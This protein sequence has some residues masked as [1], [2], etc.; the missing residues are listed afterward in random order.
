MDYRWDKKILEK[1]YL[2]KEVRKEL[3]Y[4]YASINFHNDF[5]KNNEDDLTYSL[6]SVMSKDM[7]YLSFFPFLNG[8]LSKVKTNYKLY[9]TDDLKSNINLTKE[10]ILSLTYDFYKNIDKEIFKT[11]EN[12]FNERNTHLKFITSKYDYSGQTHYSK[13][14]NEI[15]IELEYSNSFDNLLTAVHEYGHAIRFKT[16]KNNPMTISRQAY[17]EI[18]S[19]FMEILAID[20]FTN[21]DAF[22]H[23]KYNE[24]KKY[25]NSFYT[26]AA[27][28]NFKMFIKYLY[29]NFKLNND[30][31]GYTAFKHYLNDNYNISANQLK[32]IY[33]FTSSYFMRYV[34]S[35]FVTF[36]LYSI[37]N[38]DK[39][40]AIYLYK[41]ILKLTDEN[42]IDIDNKLKKM[43]IIIGNNVDAF[44]KKLERK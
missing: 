17:Q 25:F 22:K 8:P 5:P 44:T 35:L 26:Q 40:K 10:D 3:Y 32:Q 11:F 42:P 18:E 41:E 6:K 4:L 2:N 31:T 24:K 37:Y 33:E 27:F 38:S 29:D 1:L 13:S 16:L 23:L 43:N 15:F 19:T 34:L 30:D 36:E 9:K 14:S 39:Q 28:I 12:L 7:F 21:L 20:Y